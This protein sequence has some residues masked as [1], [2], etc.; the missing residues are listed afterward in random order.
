MA[1]KELGRCDDALHLFQEATEMHFQ[2]CMQREHQSWLWRTRRR[3]G[4]MQIC[5]VT[6]LMMSCWEGSVLRD[7]RSVGW[8]YQEMNKDWLFIWLEQ[9]MIIVEE[10]KW[11]FECAPLVVIP[12]W[13]TFDIQVSTI[14][15]SIKEWTFW[16]IPFHLSSFWNVSLLVRVVW[17]EMLL[18][19]LTRMDSKASGEMWVE[20]DRPRSDLFDQV[21]RRDIKF[22]A[23]FISQLGWR[24]KDHPHLLHCS[25]RVRIKLMKYL[26]RSDYDD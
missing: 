11:S 19:H 26:R 10:W 3:Q 8:C 7:M 15:E 24:G 13:S 1:L 6:I 17:R 22:I 18:K 5:Q 20:W 21:A 25:S 23:G 9:V 4:I 16:N 14:S 12:F 2:W